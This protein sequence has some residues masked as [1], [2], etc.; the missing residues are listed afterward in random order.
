MTISLRLSEQDALLIKKYAE[1]NGLSISE[2]V[3][4]AVLEK[5]ENEFDIKAYKD[6]MNQLKED[7]TTY[8]LSEVEKKLGL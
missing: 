5:I 3:R 2:L 4:Q 1:I 7:N 8:S 6:A